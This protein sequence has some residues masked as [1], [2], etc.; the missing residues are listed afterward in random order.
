VTEYVPTANAAS[1]AIEVADVAKLPAGGVT[2]FVTN[3][4]VSP[5]GAPDVLNVTAEEKLAT[6]VTFVVVDVDAP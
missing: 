2:G 1:A 6:E 5:A 4:I 3:V